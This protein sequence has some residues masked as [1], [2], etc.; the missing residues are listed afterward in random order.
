MMLTLMLSLAIVSDSL[1]SMRWGQRPDAELAERGREDNASDHMY[2]I[3]AIWQS[4]E[5]TRR[6][7]GISRG[8]MWLWHFI[9][10]MH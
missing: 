9:D 5:A 4:G 7:Q 2:A 6:C 8:E 10:P 1:V 3:F